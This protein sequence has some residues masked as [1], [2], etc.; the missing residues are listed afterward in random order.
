MF[1][2]SQSPTFHTLM[3]LQKEKPQTRSSSTQSFPRPTT[4]GKD[5]IAIETGGS[6]YYSVIEFFNELWKRITAVTQEP[7]EAVPTAE[8]VSSIAGRKCGCVTEHFSRRALIFSP[9]AG[10]YANTVFNL[11]ISSL[12]LCAMGR[13][14]N[15][16]GKLQINSVLWGVSL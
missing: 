4:T 1:G 3:T 15:F 9:W 6:R 16:S 8:N 12:W 2:T 11:I 13:N 7:R 5:P 10:Y 14:K